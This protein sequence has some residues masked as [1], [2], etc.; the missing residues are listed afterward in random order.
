[1]SPNYAQI[2]KTAGVAEGTVRNVL[3]RRAFKRPPL[4]RT[5]A[6]IR[7]AL[8]ELYGESAVLIL[9]PT[10]EPASHV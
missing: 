9:P 5:V 2:A 8:R 4:P 1:M 10:K 3:Y 6:A 7:A